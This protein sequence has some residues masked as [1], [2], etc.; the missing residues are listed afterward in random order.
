V[1]TTFGSSLKH[2]RSR[3]VPVGILLED[4]SQGQI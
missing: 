4:C 3:Y 2:Q 1:T